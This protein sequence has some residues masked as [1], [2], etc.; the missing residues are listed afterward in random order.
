MATLT[1][2]QVAASSSLT[3]T[4]KAKQNREAAK[5]AALIAL[6]YRQRVNVQDPKAVEAWL[7]LM[8][9][10]LIKVSDGGARDAAAFFNALRRIEAP[11]AGAFRATPSL[12]MIDE[13]V[14]KSLLTVGPFD[15]MNKMSEI[16]R[17]DVDPVTR[18]AMLADAKKVTS[19]KIASAVVRHAQAGG[20]QT[21]YEN[22]EKDAV[23]LG[24]I[25]VTRAKPCFFCAMLASRG[26]HYR[27]FKE[28]AFD[29]SDAR[30][31]GEGDAKVHDECGCSLKAVYSEDDH[32]LVNNEVFADLWSEWG[33]G[34]GDATLR[35]R[36]GYEHWRETGE[37]MSWAEANA[38][39]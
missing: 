29:M 11:K 23:A 35:F 6:Y 3:S 34:G 19:E 39:L 5:V 10:R 38:G 24:W 28:G 1:E 8:I 9:P 26:I 37:K 36:R 33:A 21:V 22:A 20:R 32:V 31:S 27:A 14:R 30:F 2:A 12:G 4:F 17:L 7:D 25:R 15:Y 18:R 16:Q 13:G